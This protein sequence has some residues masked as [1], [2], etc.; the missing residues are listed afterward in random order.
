MILS[1]LRDYLQQRNQ[2]T[3]ADLVQHFQ[4]DATALRG[5]LDKWIR[6]GYL[7]S[8]PLKSGCGTNCCQCDPLLTEVYQWINK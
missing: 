4:I 8:I 5:M 7:R 6:K 2:V 3:M 1:E